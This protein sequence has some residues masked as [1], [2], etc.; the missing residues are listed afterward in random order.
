MDMFSKE[1]RIAASMNEASSMPKGM[2]WSVVCV[3]KVFLTMYSRPFV[4]S[5]YNTEDRE[6]NFSL[7]LTHG[8][9]YNVIQHSVNVLERRGSSYNSLRICGRKYQKN[10]AGSPA[11][12]QK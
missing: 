4:R 3:F 1:T 11:P 9:R 7:L 5:M 8:T 2:K 12:A 6:Q 10:D